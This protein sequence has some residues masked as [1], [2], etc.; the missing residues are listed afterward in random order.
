MQNFC[1]TRNLKSQKT[2]YELMDLLKLGEK[3]NWA[4]QVEIKQILNHL[5]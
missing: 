5:V 1:V 4:M 3:T 2:K